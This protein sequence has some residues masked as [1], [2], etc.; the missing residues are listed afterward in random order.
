M[1]ADGQS[2]QCSFQLGKELVSNLKEKTKHTV[3]DGS[4]SKGLEVSRVLPPVSWFSGPSCKKSFQKTS[5]TSYK[6]A[7]QMKRG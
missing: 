5:E 4:S 2:L 6:A 3:T 7:P 1:E